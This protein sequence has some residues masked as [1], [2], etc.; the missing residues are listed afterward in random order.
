MESERITRPHHLP[1]DVEGGGERSTE[2]F[3]I[4]PRE[5]VI[6]RVVFRRFFLVFQLIIAYHKLFTG[7]CTKCFVCRLIFVWLAI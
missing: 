4:E 6:D 7:P 2:R 5:T 1:D 3:V